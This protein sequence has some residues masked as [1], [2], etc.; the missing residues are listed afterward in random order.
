MNEV[1]G[2]GNLCALLL[3]YVICVIY[4]VKRMNGYRIRILG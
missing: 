3:R 1:A 2:L 4:D